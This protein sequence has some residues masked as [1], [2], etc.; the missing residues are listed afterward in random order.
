MTQNVVLFFSLLLLGSTAFSQDT[1]TKKQWRKQKK[2]F[3]LPGRPWT[4]EIPIWVPGFAGSFAHGD[5]EIEGEDG[6][7]P[8]HPIEPPPG[9]G[10]GEII[11]RLFQKDW[12]L[13]FFLLTRVVYEKNRF[14]TQLDGLSG[15]V[16]SSIKFEYNNQEIVQASFRTTNLRL[17]AGYKIV[18][19]ESKNNKFRYELFGY[20]G[21]R[22][23][24]HKIY[25][26]L[27]GTINNLDISPAWVEPI[28]GIINQFTFKRWFIVAQGDYGGFF[29][30][31]KY[32]DQISLYACY[33]IGRLTSIKAGWNHLEINHSGTFLKE[34]YKIKTTFSG[35]SIGLAFHF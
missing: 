27:N 29:V 20:L 3:L 14:L 9:G 12:Y 16:G 1:I 6:V 21:A 2:S 19:A 17:Y 35:P 11:S 8:E 32:S 13:H 5:V 24:F 10:I 28:I 30:N 34:D 33:R 26:D 22:I 23:H 15:A 25:S 7:D 18:Q 4:V 31:S